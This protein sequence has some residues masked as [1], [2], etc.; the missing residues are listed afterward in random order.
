MIFD[1]SC[2]LIRMKSLAT[3]RTRLAIILALA[4]V[5]SSDAALAALVCA[6]SMGCHSGSFSMGEQPAAGDA[7]SVTA[8]ARAMPCCPRSAELA[9][10]CADPAMGCCTLEQGGSPPAVVISKSSPTRAK[11]HLALSSVAVAAH[12][13]AAEQFDHVSRIDA[14]LFVKPVDQKKTDLRI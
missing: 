12:P 1:Q 8:G 6:R 4:V 7:S 5:M 11:S 13:S 14:S 3:S 2:R 10:Q 9:M